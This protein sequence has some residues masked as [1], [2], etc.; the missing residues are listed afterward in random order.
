MSKHQSYNDASQGSPNLEAL[1]FLQNN[2]PPDVISGLL[3]TAKVS[4]TTGGNAG[5]AVDIPVGAEIMDV[6]VQCTRSNGSGSMQLKT[7]ALSPVAISN[8]IAAVTEDVVARAG[9]L[10]MTYKYVGADGVA[11]FAN[12][13]ADAADVFVVYKK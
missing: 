1:E 6:V 3:R 5:V 7:N 2:F 9:T 4:I 8:A 10:D 13:A 11:V 12:A